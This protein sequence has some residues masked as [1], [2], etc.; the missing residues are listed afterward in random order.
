MSNPFSKEDYFKVRLP[1]ALFR[2]VLIISKDGAMA[3][4]GQPVPVFDQ[5]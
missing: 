4:P 5:L 2:G 3:Q 1:M